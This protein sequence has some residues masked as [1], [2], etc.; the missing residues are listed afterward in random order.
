MVLQ[1][2][3]QRMQ[4]PSGSIHIVCRPGPIQLKKLDGELGCMSWLNASFASGVEKPLNAG[5]P[6]AFDHTY[7]GTRHASYVKLKTGVLPF[8]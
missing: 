5:V 8:Y 4:R 2:A 7:S 6:E 3:A 1:V